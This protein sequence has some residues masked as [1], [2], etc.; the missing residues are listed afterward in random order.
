MY[1]VWLVASFYAT[2]VVAWFSLG[3]RPRPNLD[4][5]KFIGGL[6]DLAHVIPGLLAIGLPVLTPLGLAASFCC[7][8]RARN[9]SRFKQSIALAFLYFVLCTVALLVLRADPGRVV[10]WWID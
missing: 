7:P 9:G 3:H 10:E 4:D 5:P 6:I 2:W 1:P 8:I